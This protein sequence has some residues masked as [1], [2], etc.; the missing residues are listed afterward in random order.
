MFIPFCL[1]S[2]VFHIVKIKILKN[3]KKVCPKRKI[4]GQRRKKWSKS[5]INE[6]QTKDYESVQAQIAI[7]IPFL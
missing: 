7:T 5:E 1:V 6:P 3:E 4:K 2:K